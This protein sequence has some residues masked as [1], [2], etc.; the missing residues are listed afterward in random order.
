MNQFVREGGPPQRESTT[1][2]GDES[3]FTV[4]G[5]GKRVGH[6]EGVTIVGGGEE[7]HGFDLLVQIAED[8]LG[9]VG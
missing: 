1:D 6:A 4:D 3:W 2:E 7:R 9:L 8:Q 5:V